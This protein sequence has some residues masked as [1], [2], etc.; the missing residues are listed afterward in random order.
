M[1]C[2][3]S[4]AR[5]VLSV[6]DNDRIVSF[7]FE[8]ITCGKVIGGSSGLDR[9]CRGI[10]LADAPHLDGA[11]IAAALGVAGEDDRFFF[12]LEWS[13]FQTAVARFTGGNDPPGGERC[14]VASVTHDERG[15]SITVVILPPDDLPPIPPCSR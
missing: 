1:P 4:S 14:R 15:S 2:R 12:Q 3:D 10:S 9:H 7:R 6:D 13:A 8:K 11:Q 5:V